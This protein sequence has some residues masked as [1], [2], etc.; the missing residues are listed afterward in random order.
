[1]DSKYRS[2]VGYTIFSRHS[3]WFII[4]L[5]NFASYFDW[6][7]P[8]VEFVFILLSL[9]QMIF[10]YTPIFMVLDILHWWMYAFLALFFIFVSRTFHLSIYGYHV[11]TLFIFS[12]SIS[13]FCQFC[14][15][16]KKK[17]MTWIDS[18]VLA[19]MGCILILLFYYSSPLF[20]FDYLAHIFSCT[21]LYPKYSC[22]GV[23]KL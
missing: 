21:L 15:K 13:S 7:M 2:C 8:W 3:T 16:K 22:F 19:C 23:C 9:F 11:L 10:F 6:I 20:W 18:D 12:C 4:I 1:M 17:D 14:D 5:S